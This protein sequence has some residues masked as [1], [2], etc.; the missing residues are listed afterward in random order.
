M[1]FLCVIQWI[2]ILLGPMYEDDRFEQ[3]E[4][5]LP[6]SAAFCFNLWNLDPNNWTN[7]MPLYS[8]LRASIVGASSC[9][10]EEPLPAMHGHHPSWRGC[11]KQHNRRKLN[12]MG[13]ITLYSRSYSGKGILLEQPTHCSVWLYC[14]LH[15]HH[16]SCHQLHCISSCALSGVPDRWW[17]CH[18]ILCHAW[19]YR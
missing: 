12:R 7:V 4:L 14:L 6:H 11:A 3:P 18:E 17:T 16:V 2:M 10:F 15:T 8:V 5:I 1:E 19:S 13:C 9:R